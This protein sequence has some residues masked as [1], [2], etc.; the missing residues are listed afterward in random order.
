MDQIH[1][2]IVKAV[3]RIMSTVQSVKKS[4]KNQHGGYMFASTDDIYAAVT[5]KMGECGLMLVT[6]E[7]DCEIVR[8]EKE[9]KTSQWAKITFSFVLATEEGTWSDHRARRTLY[10][11]VTGSQTFQAAQSYAEKAYLRSLFKLPTGDMDL[12]GMPQADTEEGQTALAAPAKRK[13]SSASKKDGTDKTFN[14]LRT[15]I[16]SSISAEHLRHLRET[17]AEDWNAMPTRWVEIL[18]Q[19]Y[20]DRMETFTA[21]REVA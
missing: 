6:L 5:H 4:Q 21:H 7:D 17:Y 10:I 19:E 8:I 11:Q 12:D 20:E 14:A 3:C 2:S 13:S 1:P 15:E 16:A 9:G 18:D